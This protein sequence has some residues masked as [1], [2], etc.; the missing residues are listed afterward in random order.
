[1]QSGSFK[2]SSDS[3]TGHPAS[4]EKRRFMDKHLP[5]DGLFREAGFL[6]MNCT[7]ETHYAIMTSL[8]R[9][10]DVILTWLR[11]NDVVLT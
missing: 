8:L 6:A 5:S 7:Q 10:N 2:K 11:Q 3:W 1:M 9:Q 4:G